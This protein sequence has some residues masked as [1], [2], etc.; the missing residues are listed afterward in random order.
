M[1]SFA[2]RQL[3]SRMAWTIPVALVFPFLTGANGT[4]CQPA[5]APTDAGGA[6]ADGGTC[7]P[8]ACVGLPAPALAKLCSDGTT[9][10]ESVC[11]EQGDGK[12]GWG[13]PPCPAPAPDSGAAADACPP[14]PICNLPD[15]RYGVIPPTDA[16]GCSV[17]AIC[18]PA[19]DSGA[20]ADACPPAPICNLPDCRYGVIPQKDAEGCSVCAICAPA[21]DS[22][23]SDGGGTPCTSDSD[24]NN[25]DVCG[26]L[27]TAGCGIAGT[28]FPAPQVVCNAFL[29]GCGCD[30]TEVNLICNGLPSG[31][32]RAPVKHTGLCT[33]G[34]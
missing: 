7:D 18:A 19:P 12:C 8:A 27:E 5:I 14:P 24:C 28:C 30:G 2:L 16:N 25:G 13:F 11:E 23:S 29:P 31:Y 22:G 4:G 33:D 6:A 17:C 32:V 9:L 20:A 1:T 26:F 3:R 21:P 15:C 10:T 34:G